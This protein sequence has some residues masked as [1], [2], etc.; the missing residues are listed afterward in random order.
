[1]WLRRIRSCWR[2]GCTSGPRTH[3]AQCQAILPAAPTGAREF[4]GSGHG[5]ALRA[6][7]RLPMICR[8]Y[9]AKMFHR[10]DTVVGTGAAGA[11]YRIGVARE[12]SAFIR[13][14]ALSGAS[15]VPRRSG[16]ALDTGV[17]SGKA[18]MNTGRRLW[19]YNPLEYEEAG[20]GAAACRPG[21]AYPTGRSEPQRGRRLNVARQRMVIS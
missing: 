11:P 18:G 15:G 19:R 12:G 9:A 21:S 5:R 8:K 13:Q 6:T 17:I 16:L 20:Q 1:M 4:C 3:G 7:T 2:I 10:S 14:P